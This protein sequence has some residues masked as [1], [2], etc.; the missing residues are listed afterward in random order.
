MSIYKNH[1]NV[2][3]CETVSTFRTTGFINGTVDNNIY[4]IEVEVYRWIERSRDRERERCVTD[5]KD[6]T[7]DSLR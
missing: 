4:E 3:K 6:Y 1:H 2:N 5:V 7:N